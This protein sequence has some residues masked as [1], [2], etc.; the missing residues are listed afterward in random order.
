[1][2]SDVV[3]IKLFKGVSAKWQRNKTI[4]RHTAARIRRLPQQISIVCE[5]KVWWWQHWK[6]VL[7]L[8]SVIWNTFATA[9]LLS[10]YNV[11]QFNCGR[12]TCLSKSLKLE[13][14]LWISLCVGF[15]DEQRVATFEKNEITLWS[16]IHGKNS[17]SSRRESNPWPSRCQL[18]ALTTELWWIHGER[19]RTTRGWEKKVWNYFLSSA[20]TL[21]AVAFK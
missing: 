6:K 15:D 14:R 20:F 13:T 12:G 18:D 17:E 7:L 9:V 11:Q 4:P 2:H 21:T 3:L 10:K 16:R 1:M 5:K 19:G 8:W